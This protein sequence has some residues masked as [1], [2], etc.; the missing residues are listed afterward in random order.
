MQV[1]GADLVGTTDIAD[2]EWHHV[3]AVRDAISGTNRLYVDGVE[4][5]SASV[6]YAGDFVGVTALNIGWLNEGGSDDHFAGVI[7]EVAIHDRVLPDSETAVTM[8]TVRSGCS[9]VTGGARRRC[10]SWRWVIR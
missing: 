10:G 4:E 2:G 3:V 7:D 8:R 5:A 9:V 6:S 1:A